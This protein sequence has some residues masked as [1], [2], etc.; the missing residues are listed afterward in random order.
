MN[1]K[2]ELHSNQINEILGNP[3][4]NKLK[5][6]NYFLCVVIILLVLFL[7]FFKYQISITE[8]VVI[9]YNQQDIEEK[10]KNPRLEGII[11]IGNEYVE[12]IKD[13]LPVNIKLDLSSIN[14]KGYI[15]DINYNPESQKY[16]LRVHIHKTSEIGNLYTFLHDGLH[17]EAQIVVK[18][19][20]ILSILK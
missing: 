6:G 20:S 14:I 10:Y 9:K 17:G 18:Y 5:Y 7:M 1:P 19:E 2:I 4:P 15:E 8:P 12:N 16:E 13:G 11:S 3:I